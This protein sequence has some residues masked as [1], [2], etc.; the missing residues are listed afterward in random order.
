[1]E[2]GGVRVRKSVV[3]IFMTQ[4]LFEN[5]GKR[6][7]CV[8]L[9]PNIKYSYIMAKKAAVLAVDPV[10]GS[11]LFQYLETFF[12]N[13]IPYRTYAVADG[14]EIRTNS[15][16]TLVV[17]DVIANLKGHEDEY[18]A[19]VFACGDAVPKFMENADKQY[20]KDMVGVMQTF[21]AKGKIMVGHCGAGLMYQNFGFAD[22]RRVAVH[23]YVV[24]AIDKAVATGEKFE[25]DNNF[26][27][28]STENTIW[29]MMED[30]VAVLK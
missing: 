3:S 10:N 21:A 23:P 17:D 22:G 2:Y 25:I 8:V 5:P 11:G 29:M 19:L 16:V 18:D 20:N 27:T 9:V 30:L 28:A 14:R 12:E 26:F 7:I 13:G 24:P 15:G 4:C 1:M 6:V